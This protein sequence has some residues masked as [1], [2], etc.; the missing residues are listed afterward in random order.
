[1]AEDTSHFEDE[2][3]MVTGFRVDRIP[4]EHRPQLVR[5]EIDGALRVLS[6]AGPRMG[7]ASGKTKQ[8]ARWR[9][10]AW[11]GVLACT[12]SGASRHPEPGARSQ[13]AAISADDDR[14]QS[15]ADRVGR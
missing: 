6:F 5:V 12:L 15:G 14:D 4:Q 11:P 9:K 10:D 3:V 8:R 7:R 13:C 1:M 2:V